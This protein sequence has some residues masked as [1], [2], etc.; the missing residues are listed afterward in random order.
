MPERSAR[1]A[2]LIRPLADGDAPALL[3]LGR[4]ADQLFADHGY[5]EIAEA[6]ETPLAEFVAF[7]RQ[8]VC[9]VAAS[10]DRCDGSTGEPRPVGFAV[11]DAVGAYFWLKELAVDPAFGRRGIGSALLD[12][13]AEHGRRRGYGALA[14]ST[15]RKVP[16]NA[17][18]YARRGFAEL[19]AQQA[20]V[21]LRTR[22]LREVPPGID[23]A[24]RILMVRLL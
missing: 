14:L 23:P 2:W 8:E 15:F 21:G 7:L 24:H 6:P 12:A 11:A 3:A 13:V 10:L 17:P 4:R 18:L 20:P 9:V 22:F 16:F 5:P 19:N 1:A